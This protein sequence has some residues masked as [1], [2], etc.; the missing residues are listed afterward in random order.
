M[1]KNIPIIRCPICGQEYL[2]S[3]IY[4][5]SSFFGNPGEIMKNSA[6]KIEFYTGKDMDLKEEYICDNCKTKL[7]ISAELTFTVEKAEVENV[8][9]DYVTTFSRPK[10]LVLTEE[11][12]F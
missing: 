11:E 5:P 7:K 6:G 10:K 12:L 4:I 8:E 3:E 2:P 9:E 1:D